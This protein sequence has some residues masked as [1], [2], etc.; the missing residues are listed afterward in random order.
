MVL[1]KYMSNNTINFFVVFMYMAG[2][3]KRI[4][5]ELLIATKFD[6]NMYQV[7]V[8]DAGNML[9]WTAVI[10]GPEDTPVA[11]GLFPVVIDFP[12]DY[13]YSPPIIT[14][15]VPMFH[16]NVNSDG[17]ICLSTL[18]SIEQMRKEGEKD[19]EILDRPYSITSTVL[20]ALVTIQALLG[21]PGEIKHGTNPEA[22]R[23]YMDN[24]TEYERRVREHVAKMK[25]DGGRRRRNTRRSKPSRHSRQS[26]QS[27]Q[28]RQSRQSK[29]SK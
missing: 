25:K 26:K 28:S 12:E 27:K 18:R 22:T 29:R 9:R 23:L 8:P 5:K 21:N 4:A 14:F 19:P 6:G 7:T 1:K 11:G 16:P 3:T 10:P 17:K 20:S 15:T 13:P 2:T 24:K